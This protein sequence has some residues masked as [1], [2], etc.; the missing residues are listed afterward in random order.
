M[1]D[2]PQTRMADFSF[3]RRWSE[4]IPRRPKSSSYCSRI[5][6]FVCSGDDVMIEVSETI[7]PSRVIDIRV[8]NEVVEMLFNIWLLET[9]LSEGDRVH[10]IDRIQY[11]NVV[12]MSGVVRTNWTIW[13]NTESILDYAYIFHTDTIQ[14]GRYANAHGMSNAYYTRFRMFTE[15]DR[16]VVS[17]YNNVDYFPFAH[18]NS[19][20]LFPHPETCHHRVFQF[21]TQLKR[22]ADTVLWTQRKFKNANG[23]GRSNSVFVNIDCWTYFTSKIRRHAS[24]EGYNFTPSRSVR[25][26]QTFFHDLSSQAIAFPTNVYVIEA[27]ESDQFECLRSIIG[28]GFGFGVRRPRDTRKSGL[29]SL[30]VTDRINVLD[31]YSTG[32]DD[33]VRQADEQALDA[34]EISNKVIFIFNSVLSTLNIRYYYRYIRVNSDRGQS[35]LRTINHRLASSAAEALNIIP[36]GTTFAFEGAFYQTLPHFAHMTTMDAVNMLDGTIQNFPVEQARSLIDNHNN[37]NNNNDMEL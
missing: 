21:L 32:V 29:R 2:A 10:N 37:N 19:S 24:F 4:L 36:D 9:S 27:Q 16:N 28:T 25:T 3:A 30:S 31:F 17:L 18:L 1:N 15:Q 34:P 8:Q 13:L 14:S 11:S 35:L 22:N 26:V 6:A 7:Y 33:G 23:V 12:G 5:P 20:S